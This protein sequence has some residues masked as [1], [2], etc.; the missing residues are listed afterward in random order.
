VL[1]IKQS[2]NQT[3]CLPLNSSFVS[4][5]L[6]VFV[7]LNICPALTSCATKSTVNLR[8]FFGTV[9][10][11]PLA[12]ILAYFLAPSQRKKYGMKNATVIAN[13]S[14]IIYFAWKLYAHW[15]LHGFPLRPKCEWQKVNA[16]WHRRAKWVG[17]FSIIG[18]SITV[19]R[20]ILNV[21][22]MAVKVKVVLDNTAVQ[23]DSLDYF[24]KSFSNTRLVLWTKIFWSNSKLNYKRYFIFS[25]FFVFYY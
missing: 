12:A 3:S 13:M 22:Q 25:I 24:S 21:C 14:K 1:L 8:F 2:L 7:G 6:C 9:Y 4:K 5:I 16:N 17:N 15:Q 20:S 19:S 10:S 23:S 11:S 18:N